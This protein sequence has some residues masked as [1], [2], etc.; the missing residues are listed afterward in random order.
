MRRQY[1]L[2]ILVIGL[3]LV[4]GCKS[5]TTAPHMPF[6]GQWQE[7]S[8]PGAPKSPSTLTITSTEIS[9]ETSI[10]VQGHPGTVTKN[11]TYTVSQTEGNT[12]IIQ[13]TNGPITLPHRLTLNGDTLSIEPTDPKHMILRKANWK[14]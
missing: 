9:V 14:R 6:E 10:T 1:P 11:S 13:V 12:Y 4:S 3:A 5:R 2:G 8:A 7:D